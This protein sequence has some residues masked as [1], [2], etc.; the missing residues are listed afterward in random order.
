MTRNIRIVTYNTA[1]SEID[2]LSSQKDGYIQEINNTANMFKYLQKTFI[3]SRRNGLF[4]HEWW[5]E[6]DSVFSHKEYLKSQKAV[7][8]YIN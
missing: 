6:Y 2:K 3:P 1:L 4:V 8:V 5:T 7:T